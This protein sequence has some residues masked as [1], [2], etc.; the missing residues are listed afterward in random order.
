MRRV[1]R[2]VTSHEYFRKGQ[3]TFD[4]SQAEDF[5]NSAQAIETCLRYH[6]R[7]IE[8][9]LQLNEAPQEAYDVHVRLFEEPRAEGVAA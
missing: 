9:V 5:C 2:N 3:W 8:L 1:I 4:P 6:L 7:D